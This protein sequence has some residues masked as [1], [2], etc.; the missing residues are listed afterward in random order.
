MLPYVSKHRD[1]SFVNINSEEMLVIACDSC[2]AIGNKERDIVK[3]EP[4]IVGFH[5]AKVAIMEVISIGAKPIA[6]VN[7]LS[8]EIDSTGEEIIKGI[9]NALTPLNLKDNIIV[10]GSTEEN[11]P[12]CQT[13]MGVTVIGIV[14]KNSWQL[15]KTLKGDLGILIGIPKVGEEILL[16]QGRETLSLEALLKLKE[17]PEINEIVPVGSKGILYE[18]NEMSKSN[19]LS[20]VLNGDTNIDLKKSAGPATCVIVSTGQGGL[21]KLQ[22]ELSLPI[23][24]LGHFS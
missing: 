12:V 23:N 22:R 20:I 7:N 14:N 3:V 4:E 18:L 11:F 9:L 16:D 19:G 24:V 5:T 10:T 6:L 2:G 8:V 13:A 15:P 17:Y 21:E 1:L